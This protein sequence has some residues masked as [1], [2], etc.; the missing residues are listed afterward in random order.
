MKR[1]MAYKRGHGDRRIGVPCP[2]TSP[3]ACGPGH[4]GDGGA[5]AYRC[6]RL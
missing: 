3:L 6:R 2:G 5:L 1:G 4:A